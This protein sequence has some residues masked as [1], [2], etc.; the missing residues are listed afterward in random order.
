VD[1]AEATLSTLG[2][3]FKVEYYEEVWCVT[4]GDQYLFTTTEHAEANGFVYGILAFATLRAHGFGGPS[5]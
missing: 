4:D 1:L 2:S 3:G 5:E